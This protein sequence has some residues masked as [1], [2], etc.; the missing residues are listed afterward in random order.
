M[1][2]F[3]IGHSYY[4]TSACDHDCV[5]IVTIV[6]RTAKMVVFEQDGKQR[7]AKLL[8]D[9]EGEYIIPA[10]YSMAP[11]YRATREVLPDAPETDN[12]PEAAQATAYAAA[13]E[14]VPFC[15]VQCVKGMVGAPGALS[16]RQLDF[17]L[18]L[19]KNANDII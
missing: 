16:P 19:L 10:H 4:C 5:F 8:C 18:A 17:L 3:E 13:K 7:R 12:G 6:K 1:K 2:Q 14:L 11:V 15:Q 9:A